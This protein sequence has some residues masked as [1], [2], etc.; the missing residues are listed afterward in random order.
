MSRGKNMHSI[1]L[2]FALT[3]DHAMYFLFIKKEVY[4]LPSN[5]K[6]K[7]SKKHV[8]IALFQKTESLLDAKL[9]YFFA[10]GLSQMKMK[11]H[12]R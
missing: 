4:L 12:R 5:R 1:D 7:L 6:V 8:R 10:F 11:M 2:I 3:V 9:N